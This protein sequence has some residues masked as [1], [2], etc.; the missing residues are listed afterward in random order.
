MEPKLGHFL[1]ILKSKNFELSDFLLGEDKDLDN[2]R[3][4]ITYL[5]KNQAKS[6]LEGITKLGEDDQNTVIQNLT[7]LYP[8]SQHL[9]FKVLEEIEESDHSFIKKF[10]IDKGM[11]N[12]M[13]AI[14]RDVEKQIGKMTSTGNE[15]TDKIKRLKKRI[16]SLETAYE[17]QKEIS[18]LEQKKKD[19]EEELKPENINSKIAALKK[20]NSDYEAKIAKIKEDTKK[21]ELQKSDLVQ[22]LK[23]LESKLDDSRQIKSLKQF[24]KTCPKD[25]VDE[26]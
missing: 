2:I 8:L 25:E 19:L 20:E 23:K 26:E 13:D 3:E 17:N 4:L 22:E 6:T 5:D 12:K 24:L 10:D 14:L 7:L 1:T 11:C 16:E 18:D 9:M 21:L 15:Y